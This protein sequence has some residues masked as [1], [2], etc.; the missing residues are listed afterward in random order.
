MNFLD[1]EFLL[2]TL[3]ADQL[4][5]RRATIAEADVSGILA[6]QA[7]N[8][9]G[10]GG[11]LSVHLP[12]SMILAMI[13]AM[14]VIVAEQRGRVV[15]YLM[16]STRAMNAGIPIIQA[17]LKACPGRPD[18]IIYGPICIGADMRGKGLAQALFS[19]LQIYQ[20][21][22]EGILFIRK[23]NLSSIRAHRKLG[24]TEVAAFDFN[25]VD[26]LVLSYRG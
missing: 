2:H 21:G 20:R 26:H 11:S 24:M 10:R 16:T 7:A 17:M 9:L 8:Q 1:K 19:E 23:D 4:T 6:L 15:G 25:G 18:A 13:E 22:V 5:I 3:M 12:H 14:P